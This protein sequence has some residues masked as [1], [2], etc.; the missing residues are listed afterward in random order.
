[1]CESSFEVLT[2]MAIASLKH[3]SVKETDHIVYSLEQGSAISFTLLSNPEI[4]VLHSFLSKDT[5]FPLHHHET[6]TETLFLESGNVSVVCDDC[7]KV[8]SKIELMPGDSIT[9]KIN[10]NHFLH[11]K[12]DSWILAILIPPDKGINT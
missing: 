4:Q 11:A 1:M 7:D 9:I 8:P 12:K 6:S 3:I 10:T 2:Q 5:I